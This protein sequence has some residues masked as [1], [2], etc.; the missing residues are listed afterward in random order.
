MCVILV[1]GV[2]MQ[3]G[4]NFFAEGFCWSPGAVVTMKDFSA[5]L[6]M[7]QCKNWSHKIGS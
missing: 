3:S 5:F 4:T 2:Y 6:D 1:G 7:R